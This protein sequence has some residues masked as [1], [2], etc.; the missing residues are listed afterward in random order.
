MQITDNVFVVTGGGNGIG[1]E[2]ALALLARGGR[3]AAVDLSREGL[4]ETAELA[5]TASTDRLSTHVVDITDRAAVEALPDAVRE[6][7]GRIDG[8]VNVAGIIQP[9]VKFADLDYPQMEKVLAV[10]LWGVIHTC[11][12]FLPHL[13]L[14]REAC[15]VNVSSMG[16]L[17]PVPGQTMYGASKAAV[18]LFTE[19]LYAELRDDHR[20]RHRG[21]PRRGRHRH[22]P[23][24]RGRDPRH[25]RRTRR[26]GASMTSAPEAARQIVQG[27][28]KG[29]YRVVHRQGRPRAR[30]ALPVLAP[31]RH[32][33]DREED[34]LAARAVTR[35]HWAGMATPYTVTRTTTI[36][37]PAERVHAL[38]NDFHEW[39]KWSPWE[40]LDPQL[41]RTYS[42][43]DAGV[44]ATYAWEG[45]KKAGQG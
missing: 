37:A 40:D 44:G 34:G 17:A 8:L 15:I 26:P 13:V 20:R 19:G 32:R 24:L 27:I 23:A 33:P 36:E 7:H 45:N 30:P 28:E 16:A 5:T 21:L 22:R 12:A 2:V 9:F 42:G 25:G 35:A 6:A 38:V 3:V 14:R 41:R 11:K 39:P 10:N 43:P 31:A 18:K 4:D 1:R 29:S